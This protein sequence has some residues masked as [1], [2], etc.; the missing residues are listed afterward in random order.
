MNKVISIALFGAGDQYSRYLGAFVRAHLTLFPIAE[1]WRLALHV[2]DVNCCG[3]ATALG[4]RDILDVVR[5]EEEPVRTRAMLW[6]M[7]PIFR[8]E[9][10]I[11]DYVFCRD[12]DALPTPRDRV[13]CDRFIRSGLDVHAI[14]DSQS[15]DGVM[16]GMS[17]FR[18]DTFLEQTKFKTWND[19][20]A[21]GRKS[22]AE[23]LK[24]GTDQDVLNALCL[25]S[26]MPGDKPGADLAIFEH[27]WAGWADGKPGTSTRGPSKWATVSEPTPDKISGGL[28]WG[29]GMFGYGDEQRS[30]SYVEVGGVRLRHGAVRGFDMHVAADTLS[31]HL[32]AAGFDY[33]RAAAFYDEHG[34]PATMRLV[35]EAEAEVNDDRRV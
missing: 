33:A 31:A 28:S 6:R 2:D 5:M 10:N 18:V 1:G 11:P 16:G 29:C 19:L 7:V 23:W 9:T 22:E 30:S 34:D 20:V 3:F 13:C 14:H 26:G 4:N 21:F 12:L 27:R 25:G 8:S 35:R 32:G 24:H 15:H 17:G